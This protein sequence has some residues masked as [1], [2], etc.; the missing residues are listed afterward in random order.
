VLATKNAGMTLTNTLLTA[1]DWL[2]MK[3]SAILQAE[4]TA[5]TGNDTIDSSK[6]T[7]NATLAGGSGNDVLFGSRGAAYFWPAAATRS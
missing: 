2:S 4:L 5:G 6:F 1:T 7:G 3:L